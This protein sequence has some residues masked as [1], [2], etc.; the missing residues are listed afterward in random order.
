MLKSR[1]YAASL[2]AALAFGATAET[3]TPEEALSRAVGAGNSNPSLKSLLGRVG[4]PRLTRTV[5]TPAGAPAA[6]IF[7]RESGYLVVAADD[8]AFPLLGYSDSPIAEGAEMPSQMEWWLGEYGRQID[9]ARARPSAAPVLVMPGSRAD[10]E[11]IA[12]LMTTLWDQDAPYN[13]LCPEIGGQRA[14][15][16]C[17]ATA[18]AQV[19]KYHD[20][21]PKG[22]SSISYTLNGQTLSMNF[23]Q[24]V[25]D[26]DDM[27]DSYDGTY[28]AAQAEAVATLMKACGYAT[29]MKYT[30]KESGT[31]SQLAASALRTYFGYSPALELKSRDYYPLDQW[32]T[33]F[34]ENLRDCGPVLCGG[35]D[36]TLTSGHEFVC[37]GYSSDGYFH[38]NWGW[39]GAYDGYFLLTALD[40]AGVGI[41]G[42]IGDGFNFSQDAIFGIMPPDGTP[43]TYDNRVV[44]YGV[45][46]GWVS[47]SVLTLDAGNG[48]AFINNTDRTF[49][50]QLG[51]R[52]V[53]AS[54][55]EYYAQGPSASNIQPGYGATDYQVQLPSL[56]A[57][58][59]KVYPVCRPT[60]N[61]ASTAWLDIPQRVGNPGYLVLTV[62]GG[63]YSVAAESFELPKAS[64]VKAATPLFANC[65]YSVSADLANMAPFEMFMPVSSGIATLSN[66]QLTPVSTGQVIRLDLAVGETGNYTFTGNVGTASTQPGD[67]YFFIYDPDRGKV[68]YYA[69]VTVQ[70]NPGKAAITCASFTIDGGASNVN[71]AA[72]KFDADVTVTAG[73]LSKPLV[74][75]FFDDESPTSID[76][77]QFPVAYL[78]AGQ[79][80][81]LTTTH[82]FAAGQVGKSY[83]AGLFDID[84]TSAMLA[85]VRF[86]IGM[87]GVDNVSAESAVE[88]LPG[89]ASFTVNAPAGIASVE[90]FRLDGTPVAVPSARGVASV[91]IPCGT[92]PAGVYAVRAVDAA[93]RAI[94]RKITIR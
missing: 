9:Y 35:A 89:D 41:G 20:Y 11:P 56:A 1:F 28:D 93:G 71:A 38:F 58:T 91:T 82:A 68:I 66:N 21:P 77:A 37:D 53:G 15:T 34:Y 45:L 86:T 36:Y 85:S 6:Y 90:V 12:P 48:G 40:P 75:A 44:L 69:P 63:T 62:S 39:S 2:L 57:G 52:L 60:G 3:L 32:E 7:S 80:A 74:I 88:I 31:T 23:S 33:M 19:M 14:V 87:S 25:F 83:T 51:A 29:Q 55:Q 70:A 64:N 54:G 22:T 43:V 47:G 24:T 13:D 59:Y 49:G 10:R 81:S 94:T 27:L 78:T 61:G 42:G 50:V 4:T 65:P 17:V 46:G 30:A 79:S 72:I 16:G 18:M 8:A 76:V 92:M 26:W 67:Y 73:Y 84:D 5:D